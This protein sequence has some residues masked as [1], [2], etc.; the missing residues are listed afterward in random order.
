MKL[1]RGGE[2]KYLIIL[3]QQT[4][5]TEAVNFFELFSLHFILRLAHLASYPSCL[6]RVCEKM[7]FEMP[8]GKT[9]VRTVIAFEAFFAIVSFHVEFISVSIGE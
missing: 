4:K 5:I 7:H 9:G 1:G 2:E 6:T 3:E 8:F